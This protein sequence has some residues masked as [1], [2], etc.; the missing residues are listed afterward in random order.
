VSGNAA[1]QAINREAASKSLALLKN[2]PVAEN[3]NQP[4]LPLDIAT[5][6]PR[7]VLIGPAT[8]LT[9]I[10]LGGYSKSG[11]NNQVNPSTGI[12]NAIRAINPNAQ[13]T[14]ITQTNATIT[15]ANQTTIQTA[16]YVI[17]LVGD[18]ASSANEASDRANFALDVTTSFYGGNLINNVYALNKK[19]VAVILT[20]CTVDI[21]PIDAS[22]PA[23]LYSS[24][25]GD[26]CGEGIANVITGN[27]NPTGR[28]NATWYPVSSALTGTNGSL[29]PIRSYRLSP[30]QDGPWQSPYGANAG[31]AFTFANGGNR[32]RTYMYYNRKGT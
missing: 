1:R 19:L 12:T 26:R 27:Y 6:S 20:F 14:S 15:A 32:G 22:T 16:D 8:P 3:G 9:T 11:T 21:T 4:L 2:N 5:G 18:T 24:F 31:T 25:L 23:L 13:I 29:N 7:I 30:G 28:T 17:V 10:F